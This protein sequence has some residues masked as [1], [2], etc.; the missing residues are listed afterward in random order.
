MEHADRL[1]FDRFELL[2]QRRTL[3]RDGQPV[4]L[5]G[6]AFDLLVAL[7]QR[8]GHVV[9]RNELLDTVWRGLVVEDN[10]VAMQVTALRKVL[11]GQLIVTV[12]GRG[13]CFTGQL[14]TDEPRATL[15]PLP[16][17]SVE[18]PRLFGRD[19]DLDE[20]E[21]A[22]SANGCVTL[23]GPG[24]VGKTTLAAALQSRRRGRSAWV[25]LGSVEASAPIWPILCGV[26]GQ[27]VPAGDPVDAVG[28]ALRALDLLVFDNAEHVVGAVAAI[29]SR[30][31]IA[32]PNLRV[33]VTSQV[34]LGIAGEHVTR[35]EPLALPTGETPVD[36]AL[37]SDAIGLLVDRIRA[38]DPRFPIDEGSLPLLRRLCA[39]LDCLPLALE[40]AAARVPLMGLQTVHEALAQRFSMLRSRQGRI[41]DRHRTL[42]AA[43]EWS[44]ELLSALEQQLLRA[45]S[46]F[47]GGFTVD[48]AVALTTQNADDRWD[49]IDRLATLVE[50]SLVS[51]DHGDPPRY[52][53][54]EST[55][56]FALLA[57]D[58]SG[59]AAS[60][61]RRHAMAMVSAMTSAAVA[62][63]HNVSNDTIRPAMNEVE[64]VRAAL[65]WAIDNDKALAVELSAR[66]V[67][68]NVLGP[69]R[70]EALDWLSACEAFVDD[71]S[72]PAALQ[73]EWWRVFAMQAMWV[74]H[75]RALELSRKAVTL[76]RTHADDWNLLSS[77]V[78]L[79]RCKGEFDDELA[80]CSQALTDLLDAH[81]QW[82][83]RVHVHACLALAWAA[84][85]RLDHAQA[86]SLRA[87]ALELAASTD[88][89]RLVDFAS[90]ELAEALW[91]SGRADEGLRRLRDIVCAAQWHD[92]TIVMN[93]HV[94]LVRILFDTER[95]DEAKAEWPA[96]ARR[97]RRFG[98]EAAELAVFGAARM[99]HPKSAAMLLGHVRVLHA[100]RRLSE[101][102]WP[103]GDISRAMHLIVGHL[104]PGT[105]EQWVS[106][107]GR[108]TEVQADE[109]LLAKDDAPEAGAWI[110]AAHG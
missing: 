54:L 52:G 107:G 90:S 100:R 79:V 33:L 13:Y 86:V 35:I 58:K 17:A 83:V 96:L 30:L 45:L 26:L 1:C 97:A 37:S 78:A 66:A 91:L 84:R 63:G 67:L 25:D 47:A 23:A 59:E 16:A 42:L 82:M 92:D 102:A 10:N 5:R 106:R 50:R 94:R 28:S 77:L 46:V 75:P 101:D 43:L 65:H 15:Q 40:M 105:F 39:D 38:A 109:L 55:R 69:W 24:G 74:R 103:M 99:G 22:L 12:P 27:P 62:E 36:E 104:D 11:Q 2:T 80:A 48:L 51:C 76:C 18:R 93:A 73:R 57:L 70:Y 64:N 20:A 9:S 49:L 110:Q 71:P 29:V 98:L 60:V 95:F 19:D 85:V 56:S 34:P 7:V 21:R 68:P 4:V 32:A 41:S 44:Y 72:T 81:P 8:A 31:L 53:L 89:A 14:R 87:R 108:L 61:R 88:S 6:R 3:L